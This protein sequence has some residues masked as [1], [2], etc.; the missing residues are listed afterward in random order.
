MGL[1][2]AIRRSAV[3]A[4]DIADHGIS[5]VHDISSA[6]VMVLHLVPSSQKL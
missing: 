4:I 3:C 1:R 2:P 5:I 6:S